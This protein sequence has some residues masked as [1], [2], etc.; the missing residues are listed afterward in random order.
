MALDQY[1]AKTR[2]PDAGAPLIFAF[3]GTGGDETQFFD[4]VRQ[5]N[6]DAGIISPRGGRVGTWR[7]AVFPAHGR[8][9]L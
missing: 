7:G 6:P 5:V 2:A 1:H 4:L 9:G 3:H 8:G